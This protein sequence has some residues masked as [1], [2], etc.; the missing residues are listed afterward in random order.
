MNVKIKKSVES[1]EIIEVTLP[2]Y[3]RRGERLFYKVL[4]EDDALEVGDFQFAGFQIAVVGVE[5][6]IIDYVKIDAAEFDAAFDKVNTALN[7]LR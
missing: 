5:S 1:F 7:I 3:T 2:F 4:N 6:A